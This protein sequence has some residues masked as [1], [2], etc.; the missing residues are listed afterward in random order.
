[1][2]AKLNPFL[3]AGLTQVSFTLAAVVAVAL[4]IFFAGFALGVVWRGW[5]GR[6]RNRQEAA[7]ELKRKARA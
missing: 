5:V 4:A 6:R 2:G 7:A 1:M 3:A